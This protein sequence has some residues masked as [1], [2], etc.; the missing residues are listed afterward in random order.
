MLKHKLVFLVAWFWLCALANAQ[1]LTITGTVTDGS[2]LEPLQGVAIVEKGTTNGVVTNT[3]GKYSITVSGKESI[4][5]YSFLGFLTEEVMVGNQSSVNITMA[6]DITTLSEVVVIGYGTV[7]KADATGAVA[8]VSSKDFNPG[9][10]NSAQELIV[11]KTAGV[12]IS[13]NSGAPGN[14]S[15]IRI[16]GGS[17]LNAS[18]DPLIVIDGVPI[19]SMGMGGSPNILTTLNPSDIE[20]FTILKD[21]SATAIYG[22]RASNGVILITT[23]RGDKKLSVNYK[24]TASI[25]TV[26][27][28][29]DVLSGD[30][31]RELVRGLIT[32]GIIPASA[33]NLMGDANTDWQNEIYRNALG[34]D[35][36]L[37]V[38]GRVLEVP[39]RLSLGYNNTDGILKTYKFKRSTLNFGVDPSLFDDHLTV[40]LN[41]KAMHNFNNFADQGAVGGAVSYDP[42]QPVMNGNTKYR[43]YTTWTSSSDINGA[44]IDLATANP[45]ARLD[46]TD[47]TSKVVRAISSARFDYKFH[48]LPELKATVNM[49]Y[50]YAKS[51]GHNNVADSTQWVYIPVKN[52]GRYNPYT[53]E[54]K[55][56]LFD[57]Y[58]N[59]EKELSGIDSKISAMAGYSWS[60]FYRH[61]E[62][63]VMN[64]EKTILDRK[65]ELET[66]YYN[67]GFFGRANYDLKDRYLLTLTLR[68]DA[69]S[70]FSPDTR[71]GL[72]PSYAFAWKINNESFMES[73]D[74]LSLLKLRLGYGV[75][76]QQ[77]IFTD[78]YPYF[79]T[80]TRSD[81]F[82]RYQFGNEFYYTLRPD[83]YDAEIKW[84]T[85]KTYNIGF[86]FGLY[87]DRITGSIDAY[88]RNTFDLIGIVP[89][90][91]GTNFTSTILT[92]VG[93][94]ENKGLEFIVNA[95]I[96][97]SK[98]LVWEL[99]YNISYNQNK[100]T[101]LD[102]NKDPNYIVLTGGVMGTTSGTIQL[103]KI[104][105]PARSF[106]V[107]KQMY[108]EQGSPIE[109]QYVD[110]EPDGQL[111]SSDLYPYKSPAADV[112][113][114]INS[115]LVYKN[116]DFLVN[117]RASIGNY[118]YN[119]VAANTSYATVYSPMNYIQNVTTQA[120]DTR[121]TES[122]YLSDYYIENASFFKLDNVSLGYTFD[123]LM[124]DKIRLNLNLA[125]QN[126]LTITGYKGLDPEMNGGI[127]NNVY[128]RSRN[129]ILSL[130]LNF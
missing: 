127:D 88:Q 41:V 47:N 48:F 53:D 7:K 18:N 36:V 122:Q 62:D 89:V 3:E 119:N 39:A 33:E 103:H 85:T 30:E 38:G 56:R 64:K 74:K 86:D 92:N 109:G 96:L 1:T 9:T 40:S 52:G 27:K 42:T 73:F 14:S 25:Y 102:L 59:Y 113:M 21:A 50:D 20:S 124:D 37:S 24:A 22:A 13:T 28:T 98:D 121:F 51:E 99:G 111:N 5:V 91:A 83:G 16:R 23:K 19:E 87:N 117:G 10:I 90:A 49:S 66:E 15:T 101:G 45:V 78:D 34:Q 106:Y 129:Y 84:E 82:A 107:Y 46:L 97:S 110:R 79:A 115:R 57:Y 94:M 44:S 118:L 77:D 71:W 68:N 75:T 67:V 81:A 65:N 32:D 76:G 11:G 93:S 120:Y 2:T 126:V 125:V 63:S 108:D 123:K 55:S 130:N 128:P 95:K 54:R 43:G 61:S 4:L 58:M 35:H 112:L 100:I 60:H 12:V 26:P 29:I 8:V 116:F 6:P 72:F 114:G 105:Y 69:T 17:S 80:Y 70:R 31:Y 104:G